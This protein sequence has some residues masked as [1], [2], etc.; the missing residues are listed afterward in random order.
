MSIWLEPH[1]DSVCSCCSLQST[2][3][4]RLWAEE[5]SP[6]SG[7]PEFLWCHCPQRPRRATRLLHMHTKQLAARP[8]D[9]VSPT[10]MIPASAR[11]PWPKQ[12]RLGWWS[13]LTQIDWVTVKLAQ[14]TFLGS[15]LK[16]RK[17]GDVELGAPGLKSSGLL[18]QL[19]L[20]SQNHWYI[21][22]FRSA[23]KHENTTTNM[24]YYTLAEN[25]DI[26]FIRASGWVNTAQ[27]F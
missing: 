22:V 15:F 11:Y 1:L 4:C 26:L 17:A 24:F 16:R 21:S 9:H 23:F 19:D 13:R 7:W 6:P 12:R 2:G 5:R 10:T 14:K 20:E 25:N 8:P 27:Q 18:H 3:R